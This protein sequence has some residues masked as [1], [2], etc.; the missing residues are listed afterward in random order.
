MSQW[1]AD[2]HARIAEAIKK[3]RA[4]RSAQDIADR[5]A[6][7]GYP[8]SRAQIANY[9]SGRKK[10]LDI[11][12]LLILAAALDVP[13]LVLLYPDLPAGEVEIIPGR[14]GTSWAAYLWA[15][16]VAPSFLNPGTPSN[17]EQL[18]NAVRER[19]EL[20]AELARLH[21]E[22]SA[23]RDDISKR[24]LESRQT[25]VSGRIGRLNAQINDVGGVLNGA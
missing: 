1:E 20:M 9:E 11:A 2:M 19:H 3:H 24:S 7:L 13:P 15:T 4:G 16:G 8:I 10:N 14:V 22:K 18:V 17:G 23:A 21:V 6:E 25:E 12:E 5:T